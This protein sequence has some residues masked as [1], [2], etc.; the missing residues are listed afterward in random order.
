ME[1]FPTVKS[2]ILFEFLINEAESYPW[3]YHALE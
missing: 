1:I 3:K 2:D